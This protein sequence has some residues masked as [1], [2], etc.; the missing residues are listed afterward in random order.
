MENNWN[1]LESIEA[2]TLLKAKFRISERD[3]KYQLEKMVDYVLAAGKEK[4]YKNYHAFARNWI[5]R[6]LEKGE[7][8]PEPREMTMPVYESPERKLTDAEIEAGKK[9]LAEMRAVLAK[10]LSIYE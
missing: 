2:I 9:K 1:F 8:R 3:A 7:I 10:K 4:K 6:C 5:R